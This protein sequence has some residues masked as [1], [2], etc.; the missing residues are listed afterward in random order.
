M[1]KFVKRTLVLALL[2]STAFGLVACKNKKDPDTLIVGTPEITGDF[3]AGFGNSA[4]DRWVRDLIHGY[5]T[6]ATTST[7]QIVLDETVVKKLETEVDAETGDKTFVFELHKDLEWSDGEK[8]TAEDYVFGILWEA[9]IDWTNTGSDSTTG[10]S[11]VGYNAYRGPLDE[12]GKQVREEYEDKDGETKTRVVRHATSVGEKFAGVQLLEDYK[13]S[14]TINGE[15]LP[16]FYENA[17]ASFGPLPMHHLAPEGAEVVSD[18]EG[19]TVSVKAF[20]KMA[21]TVK[22]E[23]YRFAPKVT[24][25]PYKFESFV[26]QVVTLVKNDK[27]KGNFEGKIPAIKKVI[28]KNV[29][30][31]IDVELV[32]NGE[33]DLVS[34]VIEGEKIK[35]AQEAKSTDLT[36]YSRNGYGLLAMAAHFGPTKDYR[37]R[38]AIAHLTDRQYVSDVVLD[39][40]GSIVYSEYGLAQWMYQ[41]SISW[42]D[43]N[44]NKYDFSVDT[45]NDILDETDYRFESDGVTA[46]DSAKAQNTAN[47]FR[48]NDKKEVL[49]IKH[50][51]TENNNVTDSLQA[52]YELNMQLAGIKYAITIGD[53]DT[54]LQHYYYGYGLAE[55]EKEFH[56]FNLATNFTAVYDPYYSWHSDYVGTT[57]NPIALSDSPENPAAPLAEGEKTIDEL[58]RALRRL[59]SADT[60]AYR[61]LWR[62]YQA[63]WN[64]LIPSVPLYSNQYYDVFDVRVKG[65]TTTSFHDW[66][67]VI[68]DMTLE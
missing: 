19:A 3:I 63:R 44:I 68:Y 32:I 60:E 33:L 9:S 61:D 31:D 12:E 40:Y 5:G 66:T 51:G 1:K 36:Y 27:F 58:T 35:A 65:L 56:I 47:Y 10:D 54:L 25:G 46:Y 24:N 38:Q 43:A 22:P 57:N 59:D 39:G 34:G 30:Q 55:S 26:N 28:L 20:D 17:Y 2:V 16:Y 48:Y 62:E 37:I 52:K 18:A 8:I 41:E 53:F 64:K 45:A 7:G 23:G 50:F 21:D 13:F 42:V 6:F 67:A 15:E 14:I 11:L 4:Y 29:N 49:E